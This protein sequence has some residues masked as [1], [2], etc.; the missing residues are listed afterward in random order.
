[1]RVMLTW[2]IWLDGLLLGGIQPSLDTVAWLSSVFGHMATWPSDHVVTSHANVVAWPCHDIA[3]SAC[4]I[5]WM[6]G[7]VVILSYGRVA[8]W[9]PYGR[10]FLLVHGSMVACLRAHTFTWTLHIVV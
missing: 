3:T 9:R 7:C 10:M 8:V 4:K 5:A 1:M 6:H 2:S